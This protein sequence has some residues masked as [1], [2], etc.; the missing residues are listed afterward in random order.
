M[1]L[2]SLPLAYSAMPPCLLKPATQLEAFRSMSGASKHQRTH[3]P[4]AQTQRGR[5]SKVVMS[6]SIGP[7]RPSNTETIHNQVLPTAKKRNNEAIGM[8][9]T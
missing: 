9:L 8:K 2:S 5:T 6:V 1:A 7:N 3:Y 4:K